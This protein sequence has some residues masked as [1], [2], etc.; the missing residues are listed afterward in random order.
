VFGV[1]SSG[2]DEEESNKVIREFALK[3]VLETN[4]S[5]WPSHC[6]VTYPAEFDS[7]IDKLGQALKL[8]N[9]DPDKARDIVKSIDSEK[10]KR[11]FIDV[12]LKSGAWR[13]KYSGV[14]GVDVK[15][16]RRR[17]AISQKRLENLFER[18]K[19]RCR[20][21]G[22]RIAGNRKHF[23]KFAKTIRM[24]ELVSG[25]TDES[26]HGLYLML[27]ASYDHVKPQSEGGSNDDSNLVTSC[28]SCQFGKYKYSLEE[29]GLQ[30]PFD[31]DSVALGA[32]RGLNLI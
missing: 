8:A 26:R 24:P 19:W 21:C 18:D 14:S 32:W 9:T 6:L 22:I 10:M 17:K 2:Y 4:P 12:A 1:S 23:K 15:N 13:A 29:L 31:R 11:W 28:W 25:R 30:S 16:S 20:Y 3:F 27:M 5:T 7:Q